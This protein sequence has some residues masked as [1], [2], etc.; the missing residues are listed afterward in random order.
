MNIDR[1]IEDAEN[2]DEVKEL[3][4]QK[5]LLRNRQAAY[6]TLLPTTDDFGFWRATPSPLSFGALVH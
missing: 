4:Q 1:L 2:D 6:D 5:R 3:K